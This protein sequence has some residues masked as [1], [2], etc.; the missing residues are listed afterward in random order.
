MI[1]L[2][3]RPWQRTRRLGG[4]PAAGLRLVAE[5]H[6]ERSGSADDPRVDFNGS[7]TTGSDGKCVL[8][9]VPPGKVVVAIEEKREWAG[10][11]RHFGTMLVRNTPVEVPPDGS[12]AVRLGGGAEVTGRFTAEGRD[13]PWEF[14]LA[15]LS[16]H[17][18]GGSK[19][20][21]WREEVL[22]R[23]G[24]P[25][26]VRPDGTFRATD[27]PPGKWRIDGMFF[28]P[29]TAG[30]G[31]L[32]AA[33][34]MPREFS[35]QGAAVDL[36]DVPA[37]FRAV[38]NPGDAAPDFEVTTLDGKRLRVADLRGKYVVLDFWATWCGPCVRDLPHLKRSWEA[39]KGDSDVI[40]LGLSLD[41]TDE[42]VR[43][44]VAQH[45]YG[46]THAVIGENSKI[47]RDYGVQFIPQMWLVLPDGTLASAAADRVAQQI[48]RHRGKAPASNGPA[49]GK[50]SNRQ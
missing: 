39:L 42:P 16:P 14:A 2:G 3:P 18:T 20:A 1:D 17:V 46:W 8:G 4:K 9:H 41:K 19:P 27:V 31:R 34:S 47:A 6:D 25:V 7:A 10:R 43:P 40:V 32:R 23:R 26:A 24:I 28:L 22:W 12:A 36:G 21:D 44:F 50:P 37:K 5:P 48:A 30:A 38:L 13:V 33:G 29:S 35:V 15:R 11:D 45:G 49:A